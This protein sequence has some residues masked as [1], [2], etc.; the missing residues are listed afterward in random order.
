M[1]LYVPDVYYLY[2]VWSNENS[3][4]AKGTKYVALSSTDVN[5]VGDTI[6]L[7]NKYIVSINNSPSKNIA[8]VNFDT[9]TL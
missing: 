3:L 2:A 1:L 9:D 6:V 8:I 7:F 4:S 5:I